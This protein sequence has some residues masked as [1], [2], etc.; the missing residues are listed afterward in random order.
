[1]VLV[2]AI[3]QRDQEP[4]ARNAV[5]L[6]EKPSHVER[7]DGPDIAPASRM[8]GRASDTRA[9]KL[10]LDDSPFRNAGPAGRFVKP[11]RE[12]ARQANRDRITHLQQR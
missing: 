7:L 12:I 5:H 2:F 3:A 10:V 1:M 4:R 11:L 6:V 8:N 9:F